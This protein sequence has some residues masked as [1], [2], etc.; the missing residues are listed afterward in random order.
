[1]SS[2]ALFSAACS[3]PEAELTEPTTH[4]QA[5]PTASDTSSASTTETAS[6]KDQET[7]PEIAAAGE[8]CGS[9]KNYFGNVFDAVATVDDTTCAEAVE[10]A[11]GY[12]DKVVLNEVDSRDLSWTSPQGWSC[13]D[14]FFR[15]G[16]DSYNSDGHPHCVS[17]D[18]LGEAS[19]FGRGGVYLVPEDEKTSTSAAPALGDGGLAAQNQS[20]YAT[21]LGTYNVR[22]SDGNWCSYSSMAGKLECGLE[23]TGALP[24]ST[25]RLD[26]GGLET[27]QFSEDTGF[28]RGRALLGT[29]PKDGGDLNPGEKLDASGT[30]FEHHPDG[31]IRVEFGG[32]FFTVSPDGQYASD[33]FDPAQ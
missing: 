32:H 24:P 15:E 25:Q 31:T 10:V 22:F 30:L 14:Q 6:G 1:M 5:N 27:I 9:V 17:V 29:M 3:G 26:I 8:T 28:Y 11:A 12:M 7:P 4:A 33:T 2:V 18:S 20:R 16:E 21:D 13:N 19:K 23:L